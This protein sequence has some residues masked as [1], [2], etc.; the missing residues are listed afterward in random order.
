M[1]SE[2]FH[3]LVSVWA[4]FVSEVKEFKKLIYWYQIS[5]VFFINIF[6]YI[7]S[8][9]INFLTCN[10][11]VR[12]IQV[13]IRQIL[14]SKGSKFSWTQL[15]YFIKSQDVIVIFLILRSWCKWHHVYLILTK[16]GPIEIL[17][18]QSRVWHHI[19]LS[20]VLPKCL[21]LNCCQI[22]TDRFPRQDGPINW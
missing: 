20:Q 18:N 3:R 19:M 7:M 16:I 12:S 15:I 21:H 22:V 10:H 9:K 5:V 14:L 2:E 1:F 11:I 4:S 8:K 17:D 13:K 6:P